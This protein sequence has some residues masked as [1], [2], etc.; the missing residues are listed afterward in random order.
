MKRRLSPQAAQTI[1]ELLILGMRVHAPE[2]VLEDHMLLIC[3]VSPAQLRRQID[4]LID[5]GHKIIT[6]LRPTRRYRLE[7]ASPRLPQQR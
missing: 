7:L 1:R 6:T 5:Q 2:G 3:N 4:S